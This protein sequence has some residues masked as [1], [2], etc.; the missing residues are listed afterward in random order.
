[1]NYRFYVFDVIKIQII[2]LYLH[3]NKEFV[4]ACK[5]RG[6]RC[7]FLLDCLRFSKL[8]KL[9]QIEGRISSNFL[10]RKQSSR[11]QAS[12]AAGLRV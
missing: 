10:K 2:Y 8:L 11:K 4:I 5:A 12:Y 7:L 3:F 9:H 1:M 6:T